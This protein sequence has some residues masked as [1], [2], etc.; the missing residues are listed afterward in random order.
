MR[1]SGYAY[2]LNETS[3]PLVGAGVSL[4]DSTGGVV[5]ST[6]TDS[7][8]RWEFLVDGHP[9]GPY[10]VRVSGSGSTKDISLLP[11]GMVGALSLG[12]LPY[13]LQALGDGV[14]PGELD[15]CVP[16]LFNGPA[17]Q[18]RIGT[19]VVLINGY[20]IVLYDTPTF[21]LNNVDGTYY[22]VA[23]A[24]STGLTRIAVTEAIYSDAAQTEIALA[25]LVIAGG[26]LTSVTDLRT[27]VLEGIKNRTPSLSAITRVASG[28]VS[29]PPNTTP[30][31]FV[32]FDTNIVLTS[33]ITYDIEATL[34]AP[35][36]GEVDAAVSINNFYS[37]YAT[38]STAPLFTMKNTH[39]RSELGAGLP[40][41]CAVHLRKGSTWV[42]GYTAY[43]SGETTIETTEFVHDLT[44]ANNATYPLSLPTSLAVGGVQ[45]SS[46]Y[47]V[48]NG[49]DH[50]QVFNNNGSY[51]TKFGANGTANGQFRNP[52]GICD[53]PDGSLWVGD[54]NEDRL[55]KFTSGGVYS[56]KIDNG[57]GSANGKF[58]N[59]YDVTTDGTYLYVA[60]TDNERVQKFNAS[61]RAYVSKVATP[62]PTAIAYNAVRGT[63][64]VALFVVDTLSAR[65][66]EYTTALAP[67]GVSWA[68]PDGLCYGLCA[69]PDGDVWLTSSDGVFYRYSAAG[70]LKSTHGSVG[71]GLSQLASPQGIAV[72]SNGRVYIA[73]SGNDRIVRWQNVTT[74]ETVPTSTPYQVPAT[75]NP[76]LFGGVLSVRAIPRS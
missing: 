60:D 62:S 23:R 27:Y 18:V 71:S 40:V 59:P 35:A 16:S 7:T 2:Q 28:T 26:V 63:I 4:L 75:S 74:E 76:R 14:V 12:E 49:S 61:T 56:A 36:S 22:V 37:A 70:A 41:L 19:G 15:A 32:A 11:E 20:P 17:R 5:G 1:V 47:V 46:I 66:D 31:P 72:D 64:Y 57:A 43:T 48:N 50:V 3:P 29:S 51:S 33:G 39:Y 44:F 54:L 34:A 42:D 8:G 24:M 25:S 58:N 68:V 52:S 73:D 65:I 21:T 53:M 6:T 13:A 55:Q 30:S 69:G 38:G 9:T 10:T 67:T 45:E